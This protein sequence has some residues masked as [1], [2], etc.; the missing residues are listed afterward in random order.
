MSALRLVPPLALSAC[1]LAWIV[2]SLRSLPAPLAVIA[3]PPVFDW[4][5][6]GAVVV[7]RRGAPL[8]GAHVAAIP[9]RAWV[10]EP[11]RVQTD[12]LGHFQLSVRAVYDLWISVD[13]PDTST[14]PPRLFAR[15]PGVAPPFY[16]QRFVASPTTRYSM[17]VQDERGQPLRFLELDYRSRLSL[18][19]RERIRFGPVWG[20]HKTN[21]RGELAVWTVPGVM[22]EF[23][24]F[25]N[26]RDARSDN[27]RFDA[28]RFA[29]LV[30]GPDMP[31]LVVER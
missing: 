17:H 15:V 8:A 28:Q 13:E 31:P 12:A 20:A 26:P 11:E 3:R 21:E 6:S 19:G 30:F 25:T 14:L 10:T 2:S 4:N 9:Q 27:P 5:D 29:K 22:V 16:G 23:D 7:D 1:A 24:R 18:P